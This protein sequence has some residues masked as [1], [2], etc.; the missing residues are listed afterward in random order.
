VRR[1][2]TSSRPDRKTDTL[3]LTQERVV[4]EQAMRFRVGVFVLA[5]LVLLAVLIAMFGG[6]TT[7]FKKQIPYTIYF[8]DAQGVEPGTPVRRSGV[9]IGEVKSVALDGAKGNVRVDILVDGKYPLRDTDRPTISHGLLGGD[10]TIDFVPPPAG[11]EKREPAPA[12]P[13]EEFVAAEQPNVRAVLN[14]AAEVL[15]TTQ[16]ALN[17]MRKSMQ[18]F[19]KMAPQ[20]EETNREYQA[21]ARSTRELIPELRR[22]NDE[23]AKLAKSTNELVPELRRT[24]DEFQV[25]ARNWGKLGERLDVLVQTNQE[26]M[27]QALDHFNDAV[28]RIAGTFNDENQRNLSTTLK[29]LRAG[30]DNLEDISKNT[31]QLMKESR[32]TVKRLNDS[33]TRSNE[34][35]DTMQKAAKPWADRSDR[36]TRNLDQS[37]DKLNKTLDGVQGLLQAASQGDGTLHR[38]LVDPSLYNNLNEAACM[39]TRGMPRLDRILHDFE[40]FA[41]KIARHPES[42]GLRGAVSPSSG[43]KE[44]PTPPGGPYWQPH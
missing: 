7:V 4:N 26:K 16:A 10:T 15:P 40:V 35:L 11:E 17:D 27:V 31:D 20:L 33:V 2:P 5:G 3:E 41:D 1:P 30:T 28:V 22:T 25:T 38:L 34:V 8:P 24:N 23:I 39:L 44:A 37:A 42:L 9:R 6:F 29:N 21:L 19:E 36:I 12:K 13:G 43:L 14:Q 18:R 32:E